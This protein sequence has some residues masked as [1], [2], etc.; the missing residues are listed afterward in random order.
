MVFAGLEANSL[1][2][3]KKLADLF[4]IFLNLL[5][6]FLNLLKKLLGFFKQFSICLRNFGHP[7]SLDGMFSRL[8]CNQ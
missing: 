3:F 5:K 6:T 8:T 2:F 1:G 4:K 7:L